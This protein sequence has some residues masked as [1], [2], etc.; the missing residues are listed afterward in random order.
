MNS[1]WRFVLHVALCHTQQVKPIFRTCLV[2]GVRN[3]GYSRVNLGN[4]AFAF[5]VF[6]PMRLKQEVGLA[7]KLHKFSAVIKTPWMNGRCSERSHA[8]IGAGSLTL[9]LRHSG[10]FADCNQCA[11]W[12]RLL[13]MK[14]D[15]RAPTSLRIKHTTMR[16]DSMTS[17]KA[18][19]S[20]VF[21]NLLG[22]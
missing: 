3:R 2:S 22:V 9:R 16:T 17:Y 14:R 19:T 10:L 8:E 18:E 11:L 13:T 21:G 1:S 5:G 4:L 15:D 7:T 20:K 12:K 6:Q